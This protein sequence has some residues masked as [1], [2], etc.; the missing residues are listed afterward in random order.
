[1]IER[2]LLRPTYSTLNNYGNTLSSEYTFDDAFFN[3]TGLERVE[4][5]GPEPGLLLD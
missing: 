4:V 2:T 5:V 3:R 1:M